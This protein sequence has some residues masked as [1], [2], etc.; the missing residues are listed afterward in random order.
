M[1][2]ETW[3][4]F[5]IRFS[6]SIDLERILLPPD[7]EGHPLRKDYVYPESYHGVKV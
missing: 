3:D 2:R 6:G 7:W 5:G 1:E 4:L